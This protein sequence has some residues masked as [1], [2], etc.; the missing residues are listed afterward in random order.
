[1]LKALLDVAITIVC[2]G[3]GVQRQMEIEKEARAASDL[4]EAEE[5]ECGRKYPDR[6]TK[7]QVDRVRC[8]T[9][10]EMKYARY[11]MPTQHL[12][13]YGHRTAK[14]IV[15]AER[16]DQGTTTAAQFELE[17]A[18][19]HSEYIATVDKRQTDQALVAAAERSAVNTVSRTNT[20]VVQPMPQRIPVCNSLGCF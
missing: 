7:P 12:S 5:V 10:A 16:Y 11:H 3:C 17:K 15:A 6:T 8:F 14:L 9:D 19:A 18:Q 1:M 4:R 13:D 2:C 20:V